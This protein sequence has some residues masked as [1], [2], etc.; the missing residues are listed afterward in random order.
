MND[1]ALNFIDNVSSSRQRSTNLNKRNVGAF[2]LTKD[3]ALEAK[4]DVLTVKV[5]KLLTSVNKT[6]VKLI[7]FVFEET[8]DDK[9]AKKGREKQCEPSREY[10]LHYLSTKS[11]SWPFLPSI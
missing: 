6:T 7:V 8:K 9:A 10:Q 1:L 11:S 3:H 2:A 4:L 5:N